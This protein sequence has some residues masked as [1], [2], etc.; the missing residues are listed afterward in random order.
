MSAPLPTLL[1]LALLLYT[2]IAAL[3]LR[4]ASPWA[5]DF[6]MYTLDSPRQIHLQH[7][8]RCDP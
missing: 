1:Q 4:M 2:Y 5:H 6:M 3:P 8:K 7:M